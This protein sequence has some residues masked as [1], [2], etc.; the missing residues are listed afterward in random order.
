MTEKE[1][2][3]IEKIGHKIIDENKELFEKLAEC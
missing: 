3:E 1:L 2:K